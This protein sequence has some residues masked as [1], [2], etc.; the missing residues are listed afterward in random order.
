MVA[1]GDVAV[2]GNARRHA[3]NHAQIAH[4]AHNART[5]HAQRTHNA[6]TTRTNAHNARRGT[7]DA[8]QC[9]AHGARALTSAMPRRVP[10]VRHPNLLEPWTSHVYAQLRDADLVRA[11][12][13]VRL[14]AALTLT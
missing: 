8:T 7:V 12:V 4:H 6:R 1:L 13:R 3:H 5:T 2:R 14:T 10:Q 11:R 9:V